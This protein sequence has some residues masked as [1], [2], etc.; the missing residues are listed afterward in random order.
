MRWHLRRSEVLSSAFFLYT[1][2][3]TPFFPDRPHLHLQPLL[4]ALL[5]IALHCILAWAERCGPQ[6]LWSR[7]RDWTPILVTL[8]AF[9]EMDL[10]QPS[11]FPH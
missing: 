5:V 2:A 9:Q 10:F 7:I 6:L 1:A 4:L 8:I 11:H 3:L